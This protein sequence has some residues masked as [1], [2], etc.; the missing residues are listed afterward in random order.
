MAASNKKSDDQLE[1]M[2]ALQAA[3]DRN[4]S[5]E[6]VRLDR[7]GEDPPAR[8]R[9]LELTD[10]A[11]VVEELQ[12][13][14]HEFHAPVG[15]RLDLFFSLGGTLFSCSARVIESRAVVQL[16]QKRF[17]PGL[18]LTRPSKVAPGQRRAVYRVSLAGLM[19]P[20]MVELWLDRESEA[21][22]PGASSSSEEASDP[23]ASGA[24]QQGAPSA[25]SA[26]ATRKKDG[27]D[28]SDE[29]GS[30]DDHTH[31][32][33]READFYG[34][35]VDASDRGLGLCLYDCVY[36]RLRQLSEVWV[37]IGNIDSGEPLCFKAQVRRSFV[38]RDTD[39]R[40]GLRILDVDQPSVAR[41]VRR[42]GAYLTEV[43]RQQ[44]RRQRGGG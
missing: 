33:Q 40:V 35:L 13:I 44:R 12:I 14:G 19:R 36:S 1:G 9:L 6:V 30:S 38:V 20:P 39:A 4:A 27:L 5:V 7:E 8:G 15:T 26:P 2:E 16:N 22:L 37:R 28:D 3:C 21:R 17:V 11:L 43:E 25:R 32:P 34:H 24:E 41:Q 42:L 29:A 18:R 10:D 31:P 23:S